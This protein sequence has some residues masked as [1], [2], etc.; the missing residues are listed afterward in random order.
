MEKILSEIPDVSVSGRPGNL[1]KGA[2][3]VCQEPDK[4]WELYYICG[5]D[6]SNKFLV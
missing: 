5:K 3:S 2:S 4:I 6:A 1:R